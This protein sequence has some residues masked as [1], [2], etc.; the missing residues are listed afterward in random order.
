[1]T[2]THNVSTGRDELGKILDKCRA[3]SEKTFENAVVM[4]SELYTSA[5]IA[6]LEQRA[7]FS[8]EWICVGREEQVPRAG[9]FFTESVNEY[10]VIIVRSNDDQLLALANVCRHRGMRLAKGSG[11]AEAFT[12]PYHAWTYNL[13]GSLR[14][15][16]FM[17]DMPGFDPGSVQLPAMKLECWQG[18]IYVCLDPDADPLAPRLSGLARMMAKAPIDKLELVFL[19]TVEYACNWK[20]L[21]ENFCESYHLFRVHRKTL[22][23]LSPTRMVKVLAGADGWNLHRMEYNPHD[24][25]DA[26]TGYISAVYPN[27]AI[28]F[29]GKTGLLWITTTPVAVDRT[30][31][32]LGV[33]S[34]PDIDG[35][36]ISAEFR[37]KTR[38]FVFSFLSEDKEIIES[39][40]RNLPVFEPAQPYCDMERTNWE[41]GQYLVRRLLAEAAQ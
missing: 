12:C 37:E 5:A 40:Q 7:I 34:P 11:N 36:E 27:H 1:M 9:D 15:A 6:E 18:F 25:V 8:K 13:D 31:V 38:E 10:P 29:G 20:V 30:R 3:W 41:F 4:P 35:G 19:E 26:H 16:P 32:N 39:V 23:P 14:G 22:E 33:S 21:L 28:S 24:G 2:D 17:R